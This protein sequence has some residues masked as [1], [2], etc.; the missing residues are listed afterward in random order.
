MVVN[1]LQLKGKP[2]QAL[3]K[4]NILPEATAPEICYNAV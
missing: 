2:T 1:D 4:E 3:P